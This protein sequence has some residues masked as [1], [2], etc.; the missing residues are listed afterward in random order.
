MTLLNQRTLVG[1][2]LIGEGDTARLPI[3]FESRG[4]EYIESSKGLSRAF[5]LISIL[6]DV[7]HEMVHDSIYINESIRN[8]LN[9]R[10]QLFH[11][12]LTGKNK[13]IENL[14]AISLDK[15]KHIENLEAIFLDK[16]KHIENLEAIAL[17]N[18]RH[19]ENLENMIADKDKQIKQLEMVIDEK[20]KSVFQ[21][22]KMNND[23]QQSSTSTIAWIRKKFLNKKEIRICSTSDY[24]D[25]NWYLTQYPDVKASGINPVIHYVQFGALEQ[26]DPGPNFST[27]NYLKANPKV[28]RKG[29]NPLFHFEQKKKKAA[30][31]I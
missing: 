6:S 27:K 10:S 8:M 22:N 23:F 28:R 19:I 25:A 12:E 1:S 7:E 5:Y 16:N 2:L 20:E 9:S 18:S 15:N 24:F 17:D 11:Q 26:R 31:N 4:D 30:I 21:R 29:I 3:L 13:H 14:E